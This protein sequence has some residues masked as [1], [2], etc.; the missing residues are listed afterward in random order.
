MGR[1]AVD[2]A[3]GHPPSGGWSGVAP[4]QVVAGLQPSSEVQEGLTIAGAL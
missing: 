1:I 2:G 3:A 4:G